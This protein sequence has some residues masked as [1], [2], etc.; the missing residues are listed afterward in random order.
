MERMG[1]LESI[2][3][4]S[5]LFSGV[6]GT[7][8]RVNEALKM[9]PELVNQAPYTE[10]WMVEVEPSSWEADRANLLTAARYAELITKLSKT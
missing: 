6:S 1:T 4:V 10:G 3:T 2:K 8:L 9:R 7:V 5:D